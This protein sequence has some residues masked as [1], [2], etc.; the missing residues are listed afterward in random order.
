MQTEEITKRLKKLMDFSP[1][2]TLKGAE[3]DVVPD[4]LDATIVYIAASSD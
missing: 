3:Q 4:G 1:L 2:R